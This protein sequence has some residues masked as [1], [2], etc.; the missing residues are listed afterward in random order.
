MSSTR[1]PH[2]LDAFVIDAFCISMELHAVSERDAPGIR[3]AAIRRG[4]QS[5]RT[6]IQRRR[7][8]C[9]SSHDV[10]ATENI[11]ETIKVRL[12]YLYSVSTFR[13][14]QWRWRRERTGMR[15][16][17][18]MRRALKGNPDGHGKIPLIARPSGK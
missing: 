14:N 5:Y 6:L 13:R 1:S 4:H 15:K 16:D 3:A 8:L 7:E 18:N 17:A 11:L 9:L 10:F 12:E 2:S